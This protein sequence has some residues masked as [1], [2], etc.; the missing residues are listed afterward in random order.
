M[1]ITHSEIRPGEYA[2][3]GETTDA[4][5]REIGV[6][7]LD[8]GVTPPWIALPALK[9][10]VSKEKLRMLEPKST[11][12]AGGLVVRGYTGVEP[13]HHMAHLFQMTSTVLPDL[14]ERWASPH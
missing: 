5:L 6:R 10:A 8:G 4:L 9:G 11:A 2:G 14:A 12:R 7:R 3:A 1:S 13:E